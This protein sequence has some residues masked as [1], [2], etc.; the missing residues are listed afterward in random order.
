MKEEK[1][2]V[3][4][5]SFDVPGL[6]FAERKSQFLPYINSLDAALEGTTTSRSILY[7]GS[8]VHRLIRT[9]PEYG[10]TK[11][12]KLG[13]WEIYTS[14]V[15]GCDEFKIVSGKGH[16]VEGSVD[17]AGFDPVH[18]TVDGRGPEYYSTC[19][20]QNQ[21]IW[22]I[23]NMAIDARKAEERKKDS[24]VE[25]I[26]GTTLQGLRPLGTPLTM[27]YARSDAKH[28]RDV[29]PPKSSHPGWIY[30]P[31]DLYDIGLAEID[32]ERFRKNDQVFDFNG[33]TLDDFKMFLVHLACTF[34]KTPSGASLGVGARVLT[35]LE[36]ME[37]YES[38]KFP[39]ASGRIA[40]FFLGW[41]VY[42]L[43][44]MHPN[45]FRLLTPGG[46]FSWPGRIV[47]EAG[48]WKKDPN[49]L[50]CMTGTTRPGGSA[51]R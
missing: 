49:I 50:G 39:R 41:N 29:K 35:I 3:N 25:K 11:P 36:R 43:G 20:G 27:L 33:R 30:V 45:D 8:E 6:D 34:S 9:L 7:V 15:L 42:L 23:A 18:L 51:A 24:F 38:K 12:N 5:F 14:P 46:V 47:P 31:K 37:D 13:K 48:D 44:S 17:F 4:V 1:Q 22:D 2:S 21:L 16:T 26:D 10:V 19:G 32:R 28:S 40:G